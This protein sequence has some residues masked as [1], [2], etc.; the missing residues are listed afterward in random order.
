MSFFAGVW[1]CHVSEDGVVRRYVGHSIFC[2][3][4]LLLFL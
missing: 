3:I 4:L 1:S 2:I